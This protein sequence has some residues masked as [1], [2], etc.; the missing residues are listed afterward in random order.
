MM[1]FIRLSAML[2]ALMLVAVA[3]NGNGDD[4]G[5]APADDPAPPAEDD[6]EPDPTPEDDE[7][8]DGEAEPA[9]GPADGE[10]IPVAVVVSQTGPQ[11]ALGEL[12]LD[13]MEMAVERVNEAGGVLD[14]R[15][16]ELQVED[17]GADASSG[18]AATQRALTRDPV[19]VLGHQ[20]SFMVFPLIPVI[21]SAEIPMVHGAQTAE[22]V[23]SEEGI[24]WFTRIRT[25]DRLFARSMAQ[26][27]I[28][29]LDM[30]RPAIFHGT[31]PV[32]LGF[33]EQM[34]RLL[35]ERGVEPVT[36]EAHDLGDSDLTAQIRSTIAAEPDVVFLQSYVS[37]SA[38]FARQST[39][40]GLDAPVM[41]GPAALFAA[42][43]FG[44]LDPALLEGDYVSV[45]SVPHFSQDADERAWAEEFQERTGNSANEIASSWYAAVLFLA[46][47]IE[48]AGTTDP[49]PLRDALAGTSNLSEF[50]GV[51]LPGFVLDCDE[52]HDCYPKRELVQIIDGEPTPVL[53]YER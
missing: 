28:D 4:T 25:N 45:D 34:E 3:C 41:Y 20:Y 43:D 9:A 11:A 31:D 1:R 19:A 12:Q 23:V 24:D 30:E 2:L 38:L 16:L 8:P 36:V 15:P 53:T 42:Y 26:L 14:G 51:S 39:E 27:A 50:N 18:V 40:L 35:E 10:P 13:A 5:A 17:A 32:S 49:E 7:T 37:E 52:E 46:D 44:L 29:E 6:G 22:L 33:V 48:R 47:A 21:E